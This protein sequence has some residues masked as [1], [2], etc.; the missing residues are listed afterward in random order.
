[1]STRNSRGKSPLASFVQP[2]I[3]NFNFSVE[4]VLDEDFI[5]V[6]ATIFWAWHSS[7]VWAFLQSRSSELELVPK[8]RLK[9]SC[10]EW[11]CCIVVNSKSSDNCLSSDNHKIS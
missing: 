5:E 9:S 2:S 8:F 3:V 10:F 11:I 6:S 1:M 4:D 7:T